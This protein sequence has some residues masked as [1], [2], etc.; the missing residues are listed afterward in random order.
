M[1]IVNS[2]LVVF[3]IA[4]FLVTSCSTNDTVEDYSTWAYYAGTKEGNRYSSNDQINVD[5]VAHLQISW[6][7]STNDK[8]PA[9]RSEIQCNPIVVDGI[10]YGTSPR[11][12]LF[13]IDAT[14][15]K[16][17]WIF[18]P[19][20]DVVDSEYGV[21]LNRGVVYWQDKHGDHKRILYS[22]GTKLFAVSAA[23]GQ[24]IAD[25]GKNGIIDLRDNLNRE[26][27][28]NMSLASTTPGVIFNDILILGTRVSEG[29]GALPGHIRAYNVMTGE[30]EWIFHTIPHPDEYGY[31]TWEDKDAWKKVGGANSWAGMSLDKKRGIVYVPTGSASPDFYGGDRKGTNLFANSIIALNAATGK[32][33]WHYQVVHHDLWDRDIPA[34]PNLVTVVHNGKEIDALAQVTKQGYIFLLDRTNGKPLFP[35]EE[36]PVPQIALPGEQPWPTQP[37]PTLPEPFSR[38]KFGPEDVSDLSPETHKELMERYSQIKHR[39]PFTPPSKD[40][41]WMFPDFGGGAEWGGA[42]VDLET[43]VLY[44]NSNEVPSSLIMIDMP[45]IKVDNSS[46]YSRGNAVYNMNCVTC[47]GPELKG[48]GPDYPS[49]IDLEKRFNIRQV[50]DIIDN[51]GNRM[52]SFKHLQENEKDDLIAFLLRLSTNDKVGSVDKGAEVASERPPAQTSMTKRAPYIMTGYNRF[53]DKNGYPGNKPPWGTLNAVDLNSGKLLWKVPLGEYEELTKQG[54]PVTGTRNYGGPIVT[55]GGLIFIAATRDE[56]IRAFDKTTGK[57]LW[58]AK[59]PA[60]GYATPATYMLNGKQYIVIACGGGKLGTNSGDTY[61]AFSLPD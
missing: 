58:E 3:F 16:Q 4:S 56:K 59:L 21:G 60:A 14:T 6:T 41:G 36:R 7:Y 38:Q 45:E 61:V 46:A 12:K 22:A 9:N 50:K 57:V 28:E 13:A 8:D 19:P 52:P 27:T 32:Y 26:N 10:L 2:R 51:G 37:I 17:K 5:N 53:T 54:I 49:L 15:G 23:D 47:H 25:F 30:M 44:V 31:D 55:E 1:D 48:N 35:I 18:S 42:A 11:L 24:L 20:T 39:L 34:N 43:K 40:G 29:D 33:I